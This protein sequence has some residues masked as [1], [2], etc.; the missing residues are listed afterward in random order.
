MINVYVENLGIIKEANIKLKPLTVFIGENNTNKSWLAYSIFGVFSLREH[1]SFARYLLEEQNEL[2]TH[3]KEIIS[4][5]SEDIINKGY[6]EIKDF[7]VFLK[8]N[9]NN[10][11]DLTS[12]FF[13]TKAYEFFSSERELFEKFR[14]R[15]KLSE[16]LLKT[17]ISEFESMQNESIVTSSFSLNFLK[18]GKDLIVENK[19]TKDFPK[20]LLKLIISKEIISALINLIFS[21]LTVLP[22]ERKGSA[23]IEEN[24][25]KLNS[26]IL[27][28]LKKTNEFPEEIL[29]AI[30][31]TLLKSN[32]ISNEIIENFISFMEEAKKKRKKE[33]TIYYQL[34]KRFSSVIGGQIIITEEQQQLYFIPQRNNYVKIPFHITSSLIKS[35]TPI[36]LYLEN[37]ASGRDL[38][39]MDEPEMNLHP[40]AQLQLLETL[41]AIAN[42][43]EN[44]D[45]NC[46]LITTHAPYFLEYLEVMLEAS[47]VAKEN[48]ELKEDLSKLFEVG[49]KNA[50][51]PPEKLS[52]YQFTPE[53]KVISVFDEK[54]LTID[55]QTF[56]DVSRL[57]PEKLWKIEELRE[58]KNGKYN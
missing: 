28:F 6:G 21:E 38:L 10:I 25:A 43:L 13:C 47:R 55:L 4:S 49:G 31:K 9:L 22:A 32:V 17:I 33:E 54:N 3:L 24:M 57:I 37:V 34:S 14:I 50:L 19:R 29:D 35:L 8:Q 30:S 39:V 5:I 52:V 45:R 42:G 40:K 46:V 58:N 11:L 15:M 36:Q 51:L 56:S 41:V 16:D 26:L 7:P 2:T 53:G 44:R 23:L 18:S 27:D 48:P 1:L 20:N 12:A